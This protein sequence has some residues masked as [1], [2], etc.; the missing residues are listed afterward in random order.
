[1]FL[2]KANFSTI[3]SLIFMELGCI[4]QLWIEYDLVASVHMID[5]AVFRNLL[6]A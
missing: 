6:C 2:Q 4:I 1:M 3:F 5:T